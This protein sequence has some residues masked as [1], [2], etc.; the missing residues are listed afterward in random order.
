MA[1]VFFFQVE[2]SHGLQNIQAPKVNLV[3]RFIFTVG[4][5][6]RMIRMF[7]PGPWTYGSTILEV[8]QSVVYPHGNQFWQ[9]INYWPHTRLFL[10]IILFSLWVYLNPACINLLFIFCC[11]VKFL[12]IYTFTYCFIRWSDSTLFPVR[13]TYSC[14]T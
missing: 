6:T 11:D 7:L 9:S 5:N 12:F 3:I 2:C 14:L 1:L 8:F 4:P 10:F 13:S